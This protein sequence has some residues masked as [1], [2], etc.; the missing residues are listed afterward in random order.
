MNKDYVYLIQCGDFRL[1]KIGV[2]GNSPLSRLSEMQTGCPF[3]LELIAFAPVDDATEAE[4]RL[5]VKHDL[6]RIRG[7]WFALSTKHVDDITQYFHL[8]DEIDWT[9][10]EHRDRLSRFLEEPEPMVRPA[11]ELPP[12]P[13][14]A[15]LVDEGKVKV[16]C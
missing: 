4:M 3:R 5:H 9:V 13:A 1:Y 14:Q 6:W 12:Q 16:E 11:S 2:T 7:E 10:Q 15:A 8:L